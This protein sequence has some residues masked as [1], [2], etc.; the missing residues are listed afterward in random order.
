MLLRW[1]STSL[2][3]Y[4][5][6]KGGGSKKSPFDVLGWLR[7]KAGREGAEVELETRGG[8]T[9]RLCAVEV[10]GKVA[11]RERAKVRDG[12]RKQGRAPSA[13]SLELAGYIV[14]VC[15][16]PR[17]A[18][19]LPKVLDLYRLRWQV[20]LAFKRLKGLL[21]AGHAPK[22]DPASVRAWLQ[23]KMLV[24]L[25]IEKLLLDAEVFSPWGFILPGQQPLG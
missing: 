25:L 13:R 1:H 23:A 21:G 17:E 5:V 12:A 10:A 18:Y 6:K 2:P 22:R 11:A 16:L 20:E 19:R 3:L 14:L 4:R 7:S 15:S 24:C 8:V 9:L